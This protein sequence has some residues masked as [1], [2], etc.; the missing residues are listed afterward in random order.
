MAISYPDEKAM[1]GAG[2]P[3][4]LGDFERDAGVVSRTFRRRT[5]STWDE[6]ESQKTGTHPTQVDA[7]AST[8][9]VIQE[10][11]QASSR[12]VGVDA[13]RLFATLGVIFVHLVEA[14]GHSAGIAALG[15]FGTSFYIVALVLFATRS[16]LH[17][18]ERL[19]GEDLRFRALR[20]LRPFVVWSLIF[21]LYH[22]YHAWQRGHSF[23]ALSTWWGPFAGTSPHLW[24]L[25]FAFTTGFFT[26]WCVRQLNRLPTYLLI[27]TCL[28]G[29]VGAYALFQGWLFHILSRPWLHRYHLHRFDRW[30]EEL[31]LV[32]LSLAVILCGHRLL[33][34]FP[35]LLNLR[36]YAA[37]L[38]L[39]T[40]L[41]LET[42]YWALLHD[43][44]QFSG[45]EY[46]ALAHGA[47]LAWFLSF[48]CWGD[49]P[50]IRRLRG[51]ARHTYF[52]F[53]AHVLVL[54]WTG[55]LWVQMPGYG[56]LTLSLVATLV[57]FL[58]CSLVAEGLQRR[59]WLRYFVS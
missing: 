40:F 54:H 39:L 45:S 51:S 8:T 37:V 41:G 43:V 20:L 6:A 32:F 17:H 34:E 2:Q 33:R 29:A 42:A 30:L 38:G 49:S 27:P 1:L 24:F 52:A 16:A 15:R 11:A 55:R 12:L 47:G 44:T 19:A 25:P 14:Q 3:V 46:R 59:G 21:G 7:A 50:W 58:L 35:R 56:T 28:A 5:P 57:V 18:P 13:A 53:L 9:Q 4:P 36:R 48:V 23:A 10:K 26:F 31:P 22:G